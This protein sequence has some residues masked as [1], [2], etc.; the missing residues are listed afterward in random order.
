MFSTP[1]GVSAS[2]KPP[3][4]SLD[5]VANVSLPNV[6]LPAPTSCVAEGTLPFL[7]GATYRL[8]LGQEDRELFDMYCLK[9]GLWSTVNGVALRQR[10]QLAHDD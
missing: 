1:T 5:T 4:H 10:G 9:V 2:G 7:F 3:S 8:D 6:S